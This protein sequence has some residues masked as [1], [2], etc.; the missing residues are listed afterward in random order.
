VCANV[1][2]VVVC[3]RAVMLANLWAFSRPH[4]FTH[5]TQ[6]P[7]RL[8]RLFYAACPQCAYVVASC[9]QTPH[10]RVRT[11]RVR[12]PTFACSQVGKRGSVLKRSRPQ[13]VADGFVLL[14]CC[15]CATPSTSRTPGLQLFLLL[16]HCRLFFLF[17]ASFVRHSFSTGRAH[18]LVYPRL[19]DLLP[20]SEGSIPS[21]SPGGS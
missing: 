16:H 10:S 9:A 14:G 19:V 7:L 21:G 12:A 6:P 20:S 11:A 5:P 3:A 15:C 18:Q 13:A 2:C 1:F 4:S 17:H 8:R